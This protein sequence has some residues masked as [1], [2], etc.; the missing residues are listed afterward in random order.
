MWSTWWP[1]YC[2]WKMYFKSHKVHCALTFHF[3]LLLIV[4]I[5]FYRER[6][7]F[8]LI[9][10]WF[11]KFMDGFFLKEG[12][13]DTIYSMSTNKI[14]QQTFFTFAKKKKIFQQVAAF[15][16]FS[17]SILTFFILGEQQD[18]EQK[19]GLGGSKRRKKRFFLLW[20]YFSLRLAASLCSYVVCVD[21]HMFFNGMKMKR[22]H[23]AKLLILN[24]H[25]FMFS[26]T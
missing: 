24:I 12:M 4:W 15:D 7:F 16:T 6:F 2:V 26:N 17:H 1:Q 10:G 3:D 13:N 22:S 23:E 21:S 8:V 11:L 19:R 9:G 14:F 5:F 18:T 20:I 25:C